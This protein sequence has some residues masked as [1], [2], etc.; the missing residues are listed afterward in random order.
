MTV[1]QVC[2]KIVNSKFEKAIFAISSSLAVQRKVNSDLCLRSV[3]LS[4]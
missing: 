1:S 3:P 4:V 2:P